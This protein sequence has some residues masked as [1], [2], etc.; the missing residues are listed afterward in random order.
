MISV[1][2]L[3][4]F[5]GNKVNLIE[6]NMNKLLRISLLVLI[7]S[8]VA[9]ACKKDKVTKMEGTPV[10]GSGNVDVSWTFDK[11]HSN[12]NWES[13]YLDYSSGM[14]TG[15]F[16]NFNFSPKFAFN[17]VDLSLCKISA[18]VQLSSVDSGE[19]AR[20]GLGKC[21]RSY[22][23]VTYLDTNKTAVDPIS[24]SAWFVS[25]SVKRSGT[26]YVVFGNLKF[27]RYRSPSGNPDGM[28]IVKPAMMYLTYNGTVD[29]D[30]DGDN[31]NDRYRA[32]F[33]A[34][35]TF[36]RSDF[37]DTNSTVQWVPVPSLA[38]Q[39]GNMTAANN[40]TYGVWTTNVG[41]EMRF[42]LNM[43]FYKSH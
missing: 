21:L 2:K 13:R 40:K 14:L 31:I 19:P 35:L 10:P 16:N 39:T 29:F 28:K 32:S 1:L 34:S 5:T 18:W 42:T 17:E 11:P 8:V 30:N 37:M 20:D 26:G 15:R 22:M 6:T 33:S 41:D 4:P 12:V 38:D 9:F 7:V 3:W 23:G 24:D 27:N 25:T 36:K 43:Q